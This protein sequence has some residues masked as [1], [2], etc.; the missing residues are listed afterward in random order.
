MY[1]NYTHI[2]KLNFMPVCLI[3]APTGLSNESKKELIKKVLDILVDAYQMVDDRVYVNEYALA[4]V[5]HTPHEMADTNWS[6]QSQPARVVCSIIAPPGLNK[7]AKRKMF[8]DMTESIATIFKIS[9]KRDILA[10][11]NEHQL[12]NVASNGYIQTE[13]PAFESPATMQN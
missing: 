11:L 9:D 2:L 12:D 13:N 10:F 7:D 3:E 4:D 5:G 8:R 6:I 1:K